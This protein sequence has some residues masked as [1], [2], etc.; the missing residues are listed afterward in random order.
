MKCWIRL[1]GP[2]SPARPGQTL[3]PVRLGSQGG[4]GPA[5]PNTVLSVECHSMLNI[6]SLM[7]KLTSW[8]RLNGG[9]RSNDEAALQHLTQPHKFNTSLRIYFIFIEKK[10]IKVFCS[11]GSSWI[12]EVAVK[13]KN[14]IAVY[15][16]YRLKRSLTWRT[17]TLAGARSRLRSWGRWW[18]HPSYTRRDSSTSG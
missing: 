11:V 2:P 18:R 15:K 8:T 6:Y 14:N 4:A 12:I 7:I 16:W 10:L 3:R 5:S 13:E 17:V 9:K 1:P